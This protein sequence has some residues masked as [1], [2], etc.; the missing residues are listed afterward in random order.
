[1]YL[2]HYRFIVDSDV[3]CSIS[4]Y[5]EDDHD[6]LISS[7]V[8]PDNISTTSDSFLIQGRD[9]CNKPCCSTDQMSQPTDPIVLKKTE[10]LCGSGKNVQ[11][12][13]MDS[14]LKY[15]AI[16]VNMQRVTYK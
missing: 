10:R 9:R 8:S 5:D 3:E 11:T 13:F 15:F 12:V 6:D 14:S 2:D 16:I 4:S 1:M 7:N